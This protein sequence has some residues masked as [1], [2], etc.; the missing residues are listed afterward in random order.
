MRSPVRKSHIAFCTPSFGM[1][2]T[3][4]NAGMT[5][6]RTSLNANVA[7]SAASVRSHAAVSPRPPPNACP[8]MRPMTGFG[9]F[10]IVFRTVTKGCSAAAS[11]LLSPP[12][13]RSARAERGA[14][15]GEHDHVVVRDCRREIR[16][17]PATSSS[18]SVP[19]LRLVQRDPGRVA[20][21]S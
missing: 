4:M 21:V 11:A 17:Q 14:R 6:T 10:Q 5:P 16:P 13:L 18:E 8:L 19:A 1:Q 15:P 7:V 3:E 12:D 2:S 20:P 9:A